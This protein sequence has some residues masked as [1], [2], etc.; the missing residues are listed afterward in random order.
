[1]GVSHMLL[2]I[3]V[4]QRAHGWVLMFLASARGFKHCCLAVLPTVATVPHPPTAKP[5]AHRLVGGKVHAGIRIWTFCHRRVKKKNA[6]SCYFCR[7]R[8]A[9]RC[10]L[11]S[12]LGINS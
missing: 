6:C 12:T 2:G 11:F 1:M 10:G 9:R 3:N 7:S 5:H 4:E 8:I